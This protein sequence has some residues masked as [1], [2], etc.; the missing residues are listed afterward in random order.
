MQEA[1]FNWTQ[2]LCEADSD[3][4]GLTNGEELGDPCC[5]WRENDIPSQFTKAFTPSH[6]GIKSSVIS[7]YNRPECAVTAPEEKAVEVGLF[8]K[9]EEQRH[10]DLLI[11]NFTIPEADTT[12]ADFAWNFPDDSHGKFHIVAAEAIIDQ[13]EH[14]HHYVVYGCT[15]RFPDAMQGKELGRRDRTR[16]GCIEIWGTWVPGRAI[17]SNPSWGGRPIGKDSG[18]V[19]FSVQVHYDNPNNVKGR[20]SQDGMRIYYTPNLRPTDFDWFSTLQLSTNFVVGLPPGQRRHFITRSC[21]LSVTDRQTKQPA[22][23]H[24]AHLWYHA[25]LLGREMYAEYRQAG[26]ETAVDVGSDQVWHFDDQY[27]RNI[28]PKNLTFRTGDHLQ[29]TCVY[30]STSRTEMISIAEETSDEMCWATFEFWPSGI[31]VECQGDVWDGDLQVGES[32]FGIEKLHP[33]SEATF[34]MDGK[35]LL[36]GGDV[37]RGAPKCADNPKFTSGDGWMNC[38]MI[39]QFAAFQDDM[40]CSTSMMGARPLSVCCTE[41]CKVMC[42]DHEDCPKTS[43]DAAEVDAN[44]S[45]TGADGSDN[46]SSSGTSLQAFLMPCL[47]AQAVL[48]LMHSANA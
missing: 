4:D 42:P 18:I 16:Y 46:P 9:G 39:A 31:D 40:N 29:T 44:L 13:K 17:I 20:V 22:E 15:K 43:S 24:I 8:N 33:A 23:I 38:A 41:L 19:A 7:N 27:L 2:A 6:P 35:D 10:V 45:N 14:L 25:H 11:N 12:Y 36:S 37:T 26:T 1:G 47:T 3:N 28:L 30:D 5:L 48:L 32:A 34:V 21:K